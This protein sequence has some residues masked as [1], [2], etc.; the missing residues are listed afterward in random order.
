MV[1]VNVK[2]FQPGDFLNVSKL[3]SFALHETIVLT[4]N[5]DSIYIYIYIYIYIS[6]EGHHVIVVF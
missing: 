3:W 2:L 6:P 1:D 4:L 5:G